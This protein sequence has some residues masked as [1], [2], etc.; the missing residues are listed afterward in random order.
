MMKTMRF[1]VPFLLIAAAAAQG[2]TTSF[3]FSQHATQNLFQTRDAVADQISSFSLAYDHDMGAFSLLADAEYSVFYQT[4]G[5]DFFAAD[6]GFD[7]LVPSGSKSAFYFAGA[8]AGAFY[9]QEYAAFDTL[10]GSLTGAFKTYVSA[11]SILRL[12]WQGT[13]ASYAD[14]LF[15]YLSQVA[16]FSIDKYFPTRTTLK[17]D[18]EYGYKYFLHPFVPE[19]VLVPTEPTG[20]LMAGPGGNGAGGGGMGSGSGSGW[21][22]RQYQGD[23]GFIPRPGSGGQGIGHVGV[24]ALLAQGI[25][26]VVGLSASALRQWIVSGE[27]PFM[28]IEEFYLVPNPSSD[29][30]SWDGY[31]L[32]GRVTLNLPWSVELKTGYT[33]SDK[34][35]PGV[36]S[37]GEDGLPL[38]IVRS[39]TRDLVEVR[40]EKDFRRVK[41]Y[42]A[43]SHIVNDSTDPLFVWSSGYV[44]AGFEWRLPGGRKGGG[45]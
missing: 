2:G 43:Y 13:Y 40:L 34:T 5:L 21:G 19:T 30:F 11:S 29:A 20:L 33:Y 10:G 38:G 28:S 31:Q 23:N 41:V 24:S 25:G 39:D 32:T 37:M 12:Q 4:S 18:A 14:S 44:M 22:G 6:L 45:S 35:Y 16:L 7:Y 3:S 15:D 17:A 36:E 1:V 42:F 9:G 27:N 26:D 8:A